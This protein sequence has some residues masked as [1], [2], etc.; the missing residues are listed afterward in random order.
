ML[1][2][3]GDTERP[4]PRL[5][6]G[7]GGDTRLC[8]LRLWG[9]RRA[10]QALPPWQSILRAQGGSTHPVLLSPFPRIL[11]PLR[12]P[13][14]G[15]HTLPSP[16]NPLCEVSHAAPQPLPH[17]LLPAPSRGGGDAR[18]RGAPP[19][20]SH[21]RRPLTDDDPDS[22]VDDRDSDYRSETSNS[23]PPPYYTTSQPNASVHQ[24]PMRHQQQSSRDSY[25]DSMQSYE[26][27]YSD[28]RPIR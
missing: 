5:S 11:F 24:Y 6:P 3:D 13:W 12:C 20:P 18:F 16:P 14:N 2:E 9:G 27:D 10:A 28:Q 4:V 15:T 23:I 1:G 17:T 8:P 25:T 7:A 22:T 21:S 26:L 19:H